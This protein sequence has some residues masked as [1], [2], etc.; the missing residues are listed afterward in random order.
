[1]HSSDVGVVDFPTLGDLWSAW[2]ERHC[3]V[4]D[5][6]ERGKPF[7][8]YDWQYW[9]TA[10]EGRIRLDATFDPAAPPMNQA[11]VYRRSQTIAPQ[12]IGKGPRT[13]A[14]VTLC[15]VGPSEFA[16]WARSG[17]VYRCEDNG[18]ECGW[19]FWYDDGEPMGMRNPSPLIQIL[20]TSEEQ[21]GNIWRPLISMTGLGPLKDLLLP[22]GE[23]IRIIGQSGDK[24]M[25]R[26]DRVTA[27]AKS[28]LGA[29]ISEA[30]FDESGL[31]LE[32]NGMIEV[33]E[34]MRRGAAG[35]GGRSYETTN[36]YDPAEQSY[37]QRTME[38]ASSDVFRFWR[39]P[40][41]T[42]RRSDGSKLSFRNKVERR[43]IL[44]F[45]YN[46][47]RHVNIDSIDAEAAE[48]A[49]TDI[50]QAERFFGNRNVPGLG[51]WCDVEA[52]RKRTAP[53]PK[54]PPRMQIVLG[55]DG[56]D[57]D[58]WTGIRAET[59]EGY[60]FTPV[61][62]G[63]PTIW[64]PAKYG[65]H[66]PRLEVAAAVD[67]LFET[68][69]VVRMYCDPPYWETEIDGWAEKYGDKR[70][71]RWE[72]YR[73]KQMHAAAERLLTD[74]HKKDS[75]FTHDDCQWTAQ[76]IA[77]ARKV[78]KPGQRYGLA[79]PDNARKIDLAVCSILC[80]EAW[81][82]VTAAKRWKRRYYSYSA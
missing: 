78:R 31:F 23:F 57:V 55:F 17:D 53:Q 80:H 45:A 74:I 48:L 37:A 20:A 54:F 18:C 79:K 29:P 66:V 40:D 1:M 42:L 26:I 75:G 69:D 51:A 77:N 22:R 33:A 10:N 4:P 11:F 59:R 41:K 12:K 58:D 63:G 30:F 35:M 82:D 71:L 5:R 50:A 47:T 15:A 60:Q 21:V 70:V 8:E 25:D 61:T 7:R 72:T 16:G 38:S 9:I 52:W 76:A 2:M 36:M 73:P 49:E 65:G 27:S 81:G 3:R 28:R 34:T 24:D 6:H 32:S 56:S 46:G 44:V 64:N 67:E 62:A 13:A 68:Y 39:D 14:R 43:R 19:E